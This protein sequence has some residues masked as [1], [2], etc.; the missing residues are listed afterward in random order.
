MKCIFCIINK[1]FRWICLLPE[2]LLL[3]VLRAHN[4]PVANDHIID[5]CSP[6]F[7]DLFIRFFCQK[8]C[9]KPNELVLKLCNTL[10]FS[11]SI[12]VVNNVFL[13]WSR[14]SLSTVI[15]SPQTLEGFISRYSTLSF[16]NLFKEFS[17]IIQKLAMAINM[18]KVI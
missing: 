1:S 14:L 17:P 5:D 8:K 9:L 15:P 6:L 12:R 2:E 10:G 11:E 18:V 13:V 16:Y 7:S 4:N 3:R